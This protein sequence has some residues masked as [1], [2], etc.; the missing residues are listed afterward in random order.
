[1]RIIAFILNVLLCTSLFAQQLD[2][3]Y[4][5]P[6]FVFHGK[7]A[8]IRGK[9]LHATAEELQQLSIN[10]TTVNPTEP[11]QTPHTVKPQ[12]DGTFEIRLLDK[13]PYRQIWFKF[14]KYAYTCLYSHEELILT[15]D[16]E[17]L[18]KASVYLTGEGLSFAGKDGKLNQTM[19]DYIV[20]DKKHNS[21]F[22][23]KIDAIEGDQVNYLSKLDSLYKIQR[24]VDQDFLATAGGQ[25]APFITSETD[26]Q[27]MESK[28]LYFYR[29]GE[30]LADLQDLLVPAYAVS[31][32]STAYFRWLQNYAIRFYQ[33]PQKQRGDNKAALI[34]LDSVLPQPYADLAKAM[35]DDKDLKEQNNIY[36]LVI[37]TMSTV[38]VKD[39]LQMQ[40]QEI[41]DKLAKLEEL[42]K[43]STMP[44][45]ASTFGEPKMKTTFDASLYLNKYETAEDLLVNLKSQYKDQLVIIDI[46]GT[47]CAPCLAQMPYSKTLHEQVKKDSLDVKFVYLCTEGGS[48]EE[49]WTNKVLELQQ[50][51]THIFVQQ[52]IIDELFK[53]FNRS[54]YPTY[55][56]IKPSGEIDTKAISWIHNV[57]VDK[58]KALMQ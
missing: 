58:L 2:G 36:G 33:D 20:Y 52:P 21:D 11:T 3:P 49:K 31:N 43:R 51:G 29:K 41:G 54:G 37:P 17:K 6:S 1:M 50:P 16:M 5:D 9:I 53:M 46:W 15:F 32:N 28:L 45:G 35:M 12:K 44:L 7:Q 26:L 10:Y 4:T 22:Y 18:K 38:W 34:T 40:E 55:V 39:Y 8:V 27:Y 48:S 56:A 25:F 30:R 42:K 57:N 47:W 19:N 24:R 14:D 23:K 13:T